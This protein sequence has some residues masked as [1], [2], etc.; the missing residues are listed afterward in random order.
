MNWAE[1]YGFAG[2]SVEWSEHCA[3]ESGYFV[4]GWTWYRWD[5]AAYVHL[6]I[7]HGADSHKMP[8]NWELVW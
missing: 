5:P 8:L 3:G 4:Y 6:S 1:H 7:D 2:G